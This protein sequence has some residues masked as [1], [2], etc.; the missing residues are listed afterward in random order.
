MGKLF[1]DNHSEIFIYVIIIFFIYTYVLYIQTSI[2][3]K[4]SIKNFYIQ[5]VVIR[6]IVKMY[7][8][9]VSS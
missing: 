8:C 1:D 2:Y 6:C 9:F 3:K 4:L 7:L 5:I